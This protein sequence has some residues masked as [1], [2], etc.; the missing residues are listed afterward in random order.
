M[1]N[2]FTHFMENLKYGSPLVPS[3]T[4]YPF[5]GWTGMGR[6]A[7]SC[8]RDVWMGGLGLGYPKLRSCVGVPS[9]FSFIWDGLRF[10]F[11]WCGCCYWAGFCLVWA[12]GIRGWRVDPNFSCSWCFLVACLLSFLLWSLGYDLCF[13]LSLQ[14]VND[15][16]RHLGNLSLLCVFGSNT[17]TGVIRQ[18]WVGRMSFRW[19]PTL[20]P[21]P[22]PDPLGT[23]NRVCIVNRW[24]MRYF[25]DV[26]VMGWVCFNRWFLLHKLLLKLWLYSPHCFS[27]VMLLDLGQLLDSKC[28]A[29][30]SWLHHAWKHL[31]LN[32]FYTPC[33]P[34]PAVLLRHL[35]F[36]EMIVNKQV[37]LLVH[38]VYPAQ[39][40]V[41]V[42]DGVKIWS[43]QKVDASPYKCQSRHRRLSVIMQYLIISCRGILVKIANGFLRFCRVNG[44]GCKADGCL[45]FCRVNGSGCNAVCRFVWSRSG[46]CSPG[47]A[48]SGHWLY[49]IWMWYACGCW[50]NRW[51][52]LQSYLY[53]VEVLLGCLHIS[54]QDWTYQTL[55]FILLLMVLLVYGWESVGLFKCL[56]KSYCLDKAFKFGYNLCISS[57]R[58]SCIN[59][60][61]KYRRYQ[62]GSGTRFA[63]LGIYRCWCSQLNGRHVIWLQDYYTSGLIYGFNC[64]FRGWCIWGWSLS[65][66]RRVLL[67]GLCL[68]AGVSVFGSGAC[69]FWVLVL[70]PKKVWS[71]WN[72]DG[73]GDRYI[74]LLVKI[75]C[76]K[77]NT[78]T[79][80]V[81]LWNY[82]MVGLNGAMLWANGCQKARCNPPCVKRQFCK[83]Y[84]F[85]WLGYII[86]VF[87]CYARFF[88]TPK[89]GR[90]IS[91][92]WSPR[93]ASGIVRG[94]APL[95][96]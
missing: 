68:A 12:G 71:R 20:Y 82:I 65:A 67:P 39:K 64:G 26:A 17:Y 19:Y 63:A 46:C 57:D 35:R 2:Y 84:Y 66:C 91:Y 33:W 83:D 61:S 6:V 23:R 90:M 22:N 94:Y 13:I 80:L 96:L 47:V 21:T 76:M 37:P 95:K 8:W 78:Q 45:R 70:T 3:Y 24:V 11:C 81:N 38:E 14:T 16:R 5:L 85:R 48:V 77:L 30:R 86:S 75:A 15:C 55:G 93:Y 18:E 56:W 51:Y 89:C 44:S 32:D 69:G 28:K 42:K 58:T 59:R 60:G 74:D 31:L 79:E 25:G 1:E 4:L 50:F 43:H 9:G 54:G 41:K 52:S 88:C 10:G 92:F 87:S 73:P 34:N 53:K 36:T 40:L 7:V 27:L 62:A 29:A 72:V 49:Y